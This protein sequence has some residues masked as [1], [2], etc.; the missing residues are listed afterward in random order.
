MPPTDTFSTR[1]NRGPLPAGHNAPAA[2]RDCI[3]LASQALDSW[4]EREGFCGWDPHDALNSPLLR[5]LT[6]HNRLAGIF[7]LQLFK[8]SPF[9][10]RASLGVP[11]GYNPKAMGLFLASYIRKF[12]MARDPKALE[13]IHVLA[14]WLLENV[15]NGYHGAC[16]G[17]NFP[18]PNRSFF[19]PAGT[20]TIVNTAFI[21]L[22]FMDM[23]HLLSESV[24]ESITPKTQDTSKWSDYWR[25]ASSPPLSV[26]RSSCDFIL[27]DLNI[28]RPTPKELCFSYTP[29][30]TRLVHNANMMGA[31]LLASVF[32]ETGETQLAEAALAAARFTTRRQRADGSWPYGEAPKDQWVDNFHTG[33]VLEALRRTA[34]CLQTS[35]FRDNLLKGY[36]FWKEHM[37]LGDGTPKYYPHETYP[38]DVHSVAQAILTFLEF[39]ESD[40]E[41]D[42][43]ALR[44]A[45]WGV[46]NLQDPS[47]YFHYQIRRSYRIRIPY[48]RWSQAWMQRSLTELIKQRRSDGHDVELTEPH[49]G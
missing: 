34:A 12:E 22:A 5:R 47:G 8:R 42:D 35:E 32:R 3:Q 19:A 10:L 49:S 18:W 2:A 16:W 1:L 30:D 4:I 11:K 27:Q 20:P 13:Q 7:W 48:M 45:R 6:F 23:H 36:E 26:A 40:R 43:W 25:W 15:T 21:A 31:W 29:L 46:E 39:R 28:S 14:G 38:I 17:Y 24:S 37:F 9:N 33:F 44:V 41:A